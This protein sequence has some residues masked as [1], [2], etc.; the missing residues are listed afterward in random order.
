MM[1]DI[2]MNDI[3]TSSI[4]IPNKEIPKIRVI[5]RKRPLN[6]KEQSRNELDIVSMHNQRTVIV[7]ELKT[8]I[9][10][11]KYIEEHNY[12]FDNVFNENTTNEQVN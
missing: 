6:K 4:Y 12:A 11:T 10:L 5:V 9:D 7:K 3:S 1:N 8:K 2:Q